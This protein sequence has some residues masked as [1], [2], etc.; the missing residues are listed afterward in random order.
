MADWKS[1]CKRLILADGVIDAEETQILRDEFLGD[2]VIS[3][4]EAE[5]LLNLRQ[6]A[7]KATGEFHEFVF[8]I[9]KKSILR[10]GVVGAAEAQWLEAFVGADGV[11][12]ELEKRFLA[13]LAASARRTSPEF[14]ALVRKHS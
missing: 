8:Q 9:V 7:T 2:A 5:F 1:L 4:M 10:D 6:S 11:V 13:D 12:D 14:D 3:Q